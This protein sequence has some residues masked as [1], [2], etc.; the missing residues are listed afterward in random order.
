MSPPWG[1]ILV[2]TPRLLL[3]PFWLKYYILHRRQTVAQYQVSSE[4]WCPSSDGDTEVLCEGMRTH[5]QPGE[6][7]L[8]HL[9]I[10]FLTV[11]LPLL[12]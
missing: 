2:T 11:P 9:C 5:F 12:I 1:G 7:V 6:Y 10:M 8:S 4:E 3:K